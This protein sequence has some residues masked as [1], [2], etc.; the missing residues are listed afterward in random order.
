MSK[1]KTKKKLISLLL[2]GGIVLTSI[3]SAIAYKIDSNKEVVVNELI[4]DDPD[5]YNDV[6][7][8]NNN[9]IV[10]EL[11]EEQTNNLVDGDILEVSNNEIVVPNEE[12]LEENGLVTIV[13]Y[14]KEITINNETKVHKLNKPLYTN[15]LLEH[16]DL[17]L[18]QISGGIEEIY[19]KTINIVSYQSII[20]DNNTL[21]KATFN[22]DTYYI[23]YIKIE[24]K[25]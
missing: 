24:K 2:T 22:N 19:I 5:K 18:I 3:T 9:Q 10:K 13:S 23:D 25:Y 15:N 20:E 11:N 16:S 17:S 4:N 12:I 14:E 8:L 7:L 1:V 6:Y 21:K